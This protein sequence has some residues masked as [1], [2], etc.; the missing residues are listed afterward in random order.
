MKFPQSSPWH[1]YLKEVLD[2]EVFRTLS[3]KVTREYKEHTVYPKA[4]DVFRS[5]ELT[6]PERLQVVILGQD[7]YHGEGQAMGLSFSVPKGRTL[8]PSLKNI[9]KEIEA[10][11]GNASICLGDGDL[12]PWAE[13]GVLLLNSVMTVRDSSP[14]SHSRLGWEEFTDEIIKVISEKK[15][16]VVFMLWGK[17]AEGKRSLIDE[18]KHLVLISSHPSPLGAYRGFLGCK[19]FSEANKYLRK[20]KRNTIAW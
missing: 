14:G 16:N 20:H 11:T 15:K 13:Q 6:P 8:P 19:H 12:S 7:P 2:S 10:D 9:Y 17:F 4:R 3:E 1:P 5:L 18:E